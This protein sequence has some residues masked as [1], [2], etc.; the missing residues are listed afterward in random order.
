MGTP[1]ASPADPEPGGEHEPF[2]RR[3][4]EL[5]RAGV[6]A[7]L[8][9][10]FGALV[11]REGEILAEGE[12]RV[13]SSHDPTAHAEVVA[14]RAAA[15]LLGTHELL[16]C[17]LYASC[18]PCPMCL[19]AAWWS[20]VERIVFA[21][22]RHDAAAAGFDDAAIYDELT[23][24]LPDRRLPCTHVPHPAAPLPFADWLAKEDRRPY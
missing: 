4:L 12:N 8:G 3:T 24:P 13:L 15:R 18:E 19:A 16:G 23:R 2:L 20:R 22:T 7:D 9:G 1:A 11:V 17:T 10:P 6:A 5:A 21:A 14:L